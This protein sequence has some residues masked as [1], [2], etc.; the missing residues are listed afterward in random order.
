VVGD[1]R[2]KGFRIVP[3]CPF[4]KAQAQRPP[5]WADVVNL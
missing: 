3:L 1:A 2:A 4:F 5:D